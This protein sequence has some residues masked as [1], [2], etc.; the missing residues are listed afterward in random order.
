VER[1]ILLKSVFMPIIRLYCNISDWE[2]DFQQLLQC[3]CRIQKDEISRLKGILTLNDFKLSVVGRLLL[4]K[5]VSSSLSV[6]SNC[7]T[8][9]RDSRNKPVLVKPARYE[10]PIEAVS[11]NVSHQGNI[12][13]A[14]SAIRYQQH[15]VNGA[16]Y[17]E[18]VNSIGVDVVAFNCIKVN[19][20]TLLTLFTELNTI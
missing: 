15:R 5:A 4:R 11:F 18:V 17:E 7:L 12:A 13:V 10:D 16:H 1:L 3:L 9:A 20:T 2:P 19:L 6:G 14:V 8:F